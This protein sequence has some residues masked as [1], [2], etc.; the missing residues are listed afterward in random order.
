MY[1]DGAGFDVS[2]GPIGLMGM[3]TLPIGFA[4]SQ[5]T[6]LGLRGF[7]QLRRLICTFGHGGLRLCP[8][9]LGV[10]FV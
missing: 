3:K 1:F 10:G 5:L 4:M 7:G 6:V 8:F 9:G 2:Y